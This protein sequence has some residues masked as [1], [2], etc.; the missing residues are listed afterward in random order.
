MVGELWNQVAQ[1]A[2]EVTPGTGVDATRKMYFRSIGLTRNRASRPQK[3]MVGRR[4]NTLAH[5][6][7]PVEAGGQLVSVMSA[8][9]LIELFLCG[10]QGAVT[11]TTPMSATNS[12]LWT[13]K[14][15]STV[16]AMTLEYHDGAA[17]KR[18]VGVR[19]NSFTIAGSVTGEN[20]V[21]GDLFAQDREDDFTTLTTGLT[22]RVP[23][24]MEGWQTNFYLTAFAGTPGAGPITGSLLEWNVQIQN[25]MGRK[26]T[27]GNTLAASGTTFGEIAITASVKLEASN[28]QAATELTNWDADTKRLM[29]LEFLGPADGIESGFRR[30]VTIDLPGAWTSPDTGQEDAG[31][32]AYTFPFQYVYDPTNSFGVQIRCQNSRTA[33]WA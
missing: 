27:A 31:T 17:V 4:D 32:R 3:F 24:F 18:G 29:R 21:T 28:A 6:Q 19:V 5:T 10:I 16:D 25:N 20:L 7:G 12:R 1:A 13:F 22:D 14:P 15:S 26:Y 33:A 30:F 8:D 23:T 2:V 9:E 11:P